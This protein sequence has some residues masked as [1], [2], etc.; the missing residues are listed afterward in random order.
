MIPLR[1]CLPRLAELR[2]ISRQTEDEFG[3]IETE[4]SGRYGPSDLP[5]IR[6]AIRARRLV[7]SGE[8]IKVA[9]IVRIYSCS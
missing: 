2:D 9:C 5:R 6:E 3:F 7:L 1:E 8:S 4:L